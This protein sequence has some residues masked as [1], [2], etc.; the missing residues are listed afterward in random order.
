MDDGVYQ[1][2]KASPRPL[3]GCSIS[4]GF[5]KQWPALG[6]S[7]NGYAVWVVFELDLNRHPVNVPICIS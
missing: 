1:I 6:T 2:Q 5:L 7:L 3:P 4:L